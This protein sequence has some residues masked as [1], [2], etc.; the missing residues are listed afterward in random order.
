MTH[1]YYD[2]EK[3]LN[4]QNSSVKAILWGFLWCAIICLVV[5]GVRSAWSWE[6]D[7]LVKVWVDYEVKILDKDKVVFYKSCDVQ[8]S[9]VFKCNTHIFEGT[10]VIQ[11]LEYRLP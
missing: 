2:A 6:D 5:L 4:S 8:D 10:Q 7:H 3:R 11:K 9:L 1:P